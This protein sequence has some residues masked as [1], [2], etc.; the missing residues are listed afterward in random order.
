M[1]GCF[2]EMAKQM[3]VNA[4]QVPLGRARAP[5]G[6]PRCCSRGRKFLGVSRYG[7]MI[8]ALRG[9]M[10]QRDQLKLGQSGA[11]G[12]IL[13]LLLLLQAG[14]SSGWVRG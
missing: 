6:S 10:L 7:A 9:S 1:V 12:L 2:V 13:A 11:Y 14:G 4:K 8:G 3:E 5:C